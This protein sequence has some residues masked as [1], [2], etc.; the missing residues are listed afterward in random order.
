MQTPIILLSFAANADDAHLARLKDEATNIW[1]TLAPLET[2]GYVRVHKEE[3]VTVQELINEVTNNPDRLAIFHYGGHAGGTTLDFEGGAAQAKGLAQLLGEQK[4]LQLVFLNGCS[5]APQ[6]KALQKAGVKAVIAT[7]V[8][9]A[10]DQAAFFSGQFYKGLTQKRTIEQAFNL[11]KAA[12]ETKYKNTPPEIVI[13]R[14]NWWD[15]APA[16]DP[17]TAVQLLPWNLF[18][19]DPTDAAVLNYR[20]PYYIDFQFGATVTSQISNTTNAKVQL[21]KNLIQRTLEAMCRYNK[22]IYTQLVTTVGSVETPI[23]SSLYMDVILRNVPWMIGQQLQ[24]LRQYDKL[25]ATRLEQLISTYVI[26]A[27]VLYHILLANIWKEH[28]L[29]NTPVPPNFGTNHTITRQNLTTFPYISRILDLLAFA[30]KNNIALFVPEFENFRNAA[31]NDPLTKQLFEY[32]D[33]LTQKTVPAAGIGAECINAEKALSI[34]M[35]NSAFLA[36]YKFT[37]VRGISLFNPLYDDLQY[38]LHIGSLNPL[39]IEGPVY[40][41]D[42]RNKRKKNFTPRNS[43]VLLRNEDDLSEALNLSP[44]IIDINT[45]LNNAKPDIYMYAFAQSGSFYYHAIIHSIQVA[46][47]DDKGTDLRHTDMTQDDFD[48][49]RNITDNDTATNNIF[50]NFDEMFGNAP[51]AATTVAKDSTFVLADLAQLHQ[52]F[53]QDMKC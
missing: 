36:N 11:A 35:Q 29:H 8:P 28:R 41:E 22:D 42:T 13:V 7:A 23:D 14:G 31:L 45:F 9:I 2:R 17:T 20:L 44:F 50:D 1:D 5:T 24:L 21:N 47:R 33:K 10:D 46:L 19:T 39:S 4:N 51:G 49:G 27:R 25:D 6:V 53:L 37:M 30:E 18:V 40:Y 32:L 38:D 26:T 43:V 48:N 52:L 3:S 16:P 15:T 12:L 34:F